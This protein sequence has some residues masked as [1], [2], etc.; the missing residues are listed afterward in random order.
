MSFLC[1]N[2]DRTFAYE[3]LLL[4]HNKRKRPCKKKIEIDQIIDNT[5][6]EERIKKIEENIKMGS[7]ISIDLSL[8]D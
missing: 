3:Y 2:C 5:N 4:R 1:K 8:F 7:P 6:I